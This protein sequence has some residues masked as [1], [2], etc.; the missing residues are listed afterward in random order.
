MRKQKREEYLIRKA[1]E[2]GFVSIAEAA[3]SL[4][5]SIETV[6]RDINKLNEDGLIRKVR[7]GAESAQRYLRKDAPR[8]IR[9]YANAEEKKL[10]GQAAAQMI[11]NDS[12]VGLD[13]G[14]SVEVMATYITDVQNITFVT[15]SLPIATILMEKLFRKEITGRLIMIGGEIDVQ[16]RFSRGTL[17]TDALAMYNFDQA[18]L[19]CTALSAQ[20]VSCHNLE[21]GTFAAHL[22]KRSA[23]N[24]LLAEN[25]KLGK[26]S[27]YSY[28]DVTDFDYIVLNDPIQLPAELA[29]KLKASSVELILASQTDSES[30]VGFIQL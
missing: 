13:C 30:D 17:A 1:G 6:R 28:A 22:I 18:F 24:I 4:N 2:N 26:N 14:V 12:I 5:V 21:E 8:S 3:A 25:D 7:G 16:N 9:I 29:Q 20:C 15:N 19:S 27:L 11:R 23:Q 10:V